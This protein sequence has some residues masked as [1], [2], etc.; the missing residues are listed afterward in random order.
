MDTNIMR[1]YA[2]ELFTIADG[3][4]EIAGILKD[5]AKEIERLRAELADSVSHE[6][7]MATECERNEAREVARKLYK[8]I[9]AG[10]MIYLA[11][12]DEE[13]TSFAKQYPWLE[14][15]E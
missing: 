2:S 12:S 11:E 7:L 9:N 14:E 4:A 5:A 1:E 15:D 8:T 13:L 3:N 6:T 10:Q